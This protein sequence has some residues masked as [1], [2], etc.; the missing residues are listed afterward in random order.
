MVESL[1]IRNNSLRAPAAA[2]RGAGGL[3]PAL[4]PHSKVD[5]I[6]NSLVSSFGQQTYMTRIRSYEQGT[7]KGM[8]F[9][10]LYNR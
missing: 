3:D 5:D 2:G 1:I 7:C 9:P 8:Y 4:A 10:L 6:K